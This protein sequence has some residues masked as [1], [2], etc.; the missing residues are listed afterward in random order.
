MVVA[1][2]H[3]AA[4]PI[5][6]IQVG[7]RGV[8][9]WRSASG[10]LAALV[11]GLG[12][13]LALAWP[14]ASAYGE[15]VDENLMLKQRLE[16]VDRR[17]GEVDRI[18]LRLRLYD[19]QLE[20]LG[21]PRGD[22]GPLP[23]GTGAS[24]ELAPGEPL[25]GAILQGAPPGDDGLGWVE[26]A[27]EG[28]RAAEAWAEGI[29]ARAVTFLEVFARAEPGLNLLVEDLEALDA[30]QRAL[31]STWPAGG[32]LTSGYGWRRNPFGVRW[33]HHAGVD[34]AGDVGAPIWAAAPG[35][36]IQAGWNGGYGR[37]VEI[38]HG[39]GITT[40]YAHCTRLLVSEGQRVSR[41]QQVA[42]LG[43]TGR[44]TGPHLHFE[45]RLDGHPVDPMDYLGAWRGPRGD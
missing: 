17:M 43:S 12:V 14:R 33:R 38:D 32:L 3:D 1:L 35:T 39:F 4:R 20:S 37:S 15:L 19:A 31:P 36:V 9:A 13:A 18:L 8:R 5:E 10:L 44:S 25:D 34:L 23:P 41:G 2:P 45:V 21:G 26:G 11:V 24:E 28:V 6:R 27:E 7:D 16:S 22:H 30:L 29:E 42:T 40:L